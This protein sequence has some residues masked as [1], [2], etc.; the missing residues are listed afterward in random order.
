[1]YLLRLVVCIRIALE[2]PAW[3]DMQNYITVHR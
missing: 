1:M 3:C 2:D